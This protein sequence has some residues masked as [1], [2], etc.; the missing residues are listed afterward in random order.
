MYHCKNRPCIEP[1]Q[2]SDRPTDWTLVVTIR[3]YVGALFLYVFYWLTLWGSMT[4]VVGASLSPDKAKEIFQVQDSVGFAGQ[5]REES[6][7]K[8]KLM[9]LL[10]LALDFTKNP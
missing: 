7:S 6:A 9:T 10:E 1:F 4:K 3:R 2:I 8:L 5:Q